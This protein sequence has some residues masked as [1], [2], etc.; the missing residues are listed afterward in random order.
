MPQNIKTIFVL[1]SPPVSRKYFYNPIGKTTE[2]LFSAMMKCV[3]HIEPNTK[4]EGLAQFQKSGYLIVDATYTHVNGLGRQRRKRN[5]IIERN[6]HNLLSDLNT[7]VGKKKSK[8]KIILVKANICRLLE[9]KLKADG[10][11]V[12]NAG[13]IVP[14][15][16]SGHQVNFCVEIHK[17][18]RKT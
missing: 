14:F 6:Y 7:L 13:V 1:E 15:P 3:L 10:F 5:E 9:P 18:L 17:L 4:A 2:P 16:A 12:A 8:T 11:N